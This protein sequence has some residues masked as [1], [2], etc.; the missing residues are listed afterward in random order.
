MKSLI[1]L[2]GKSGEFGSI[3]EN[4]NKKVKNGNMIKKKIDEKNIEIKKCLKG[5]QTQ[6]KVF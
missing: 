3:E 1:S 6:K 5:K 2:S 4:V